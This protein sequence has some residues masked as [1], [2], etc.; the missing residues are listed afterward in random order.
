MKVVLMCA[1]L[2]AAPVYAETKLYCKGNGTVTN[3]SRDDSSNSVAGVSFSFQ[4]TFDEAAS[5]LTANVPDVDYLRKIR[6]SS[7][8]ATAKAVYFTPGAI[9]AEF[10]ARPRRPAEFALLGP[11]AL[12]KR[13]MPDLVIDRT[14]G[15]YTWGPHSG[16]CMAI[17]AQERQF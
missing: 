10:K 4:A 7:G 5:T 3:Y 2:T 9:T 8:V 17:A 16:Q 11:F 14:T 15:A 1:L 6:D 12:V 13:P